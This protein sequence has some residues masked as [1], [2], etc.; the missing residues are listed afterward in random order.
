MRDVSLHSFRYL[1]HVIESLEL[2]IVLSMLL[3][4][5]SSASREDA[6]SI[7][8]DLVAFLDHRLDPLPGTRMRLSDGR[9]LTL[10]GRYGRVL[11]A[12]LADEPVRFSIN[13]WTEIAYDAHVMCG[14]FD[15]HLRA[16][17]A[18][19]RSDHRLCAA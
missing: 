11:Q 3:S 2:D 10:K 8:P 12:E 9:T 15:A 18:Q 16:V 4:G 17:R 7:L 19:P 5:S 1:D 13:Q 6:L 14:P